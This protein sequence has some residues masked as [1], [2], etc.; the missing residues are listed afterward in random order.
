MTLEFSNLWKPIDQIYYINVDLM[1]YE[2][3]N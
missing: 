2:Y 1:E 3:S